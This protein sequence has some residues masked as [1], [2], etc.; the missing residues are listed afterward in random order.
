MSSSPVDSAGRMTVPRRDSTRRSPRGADVKQTFQPNNR[1]RKKTHGFRIRMRSRGAG[2]SWPAVGQRAGQ[3][4]PPEHAAY[5][6]RIHL[7]YRSRAVKGAAPSIMRKASAI[8]DVRRRGK[9]Y[10][11]GRV[12]VYVLPS[13]DWTR[14][15]FVSSRSVGGAVVLT[16]ARRLLRVAWR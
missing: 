11:G 9:R 13:E 1:K 16:R 2:G 3:P 15:G 6:P 8:G 12:I 4:Y 5:P 10:E 7:H 14:V